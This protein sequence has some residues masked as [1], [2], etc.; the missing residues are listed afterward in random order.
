MV[1]HKGIEKEHVEKSIA[2]IES[3]ARN[4]RRQ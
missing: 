1:I 4:R 2:A 3:I